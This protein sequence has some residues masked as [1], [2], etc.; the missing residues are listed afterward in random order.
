M[1]AY[2]S[3]ARCY[4]SLL[5]I[6]ITGSYGVEVRELTYFAVV[7]EHASITRAA[8]AIGISQ[9]ALTKCMRQLEYRLRVRLLERRASGVKP[10]MYGEALYA[11]AKLIAAEVARAKAEIEELSGTN[12]GMLSVGVLPTQAANLLPL[13]SIGLARARPRL[14]LR[15]VEKSR[16]DLLSGL[17]RGDFDLIVS[18]IESE[19]AVP[20]IK[21]LPL[22]RD[23][24]TAIVRWGHPA[25]TRKGIVLRDL[26]PYPWIL[27]PADSSRRSSIER[28]FKDTGISL[29]TGMIECR[30]VS[31]LKTVVMHS[32]HVGILPH[33]AP[34]LEEEANLIRSVVLTNLP[35]D[36]EIG[37]LYRSD[38]PLSGGAR[39]LVRELKKSARLK[40]GAILAR[41]LSSL[42]KRV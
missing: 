9:P 26:L 2:T 3:S 10:T 6:P 40:S 7:V 38:Y 30:S 25:A 35:A 14:R 19:L 32:N 39:A 12:A 23:R 33:D 21:Q 22:I 28:M 15:V 5:G 17:R 24:L 18:V 16:A 20:D 11:R 37:V 8:E 41:N 13:A 4:I 31:F 1:S 29:S 42:K 36:R 27:P 34:S